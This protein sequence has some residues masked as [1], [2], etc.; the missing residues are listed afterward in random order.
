MSPKCRYPSCEEE[1][2]GRGE[3]VGS[4]AADFCSPACE[5]KFE[6]VRADARDARRAAKAERRTP[7]MR[8]G[9]P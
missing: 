9:R 2:R 8:G 1:A 3:N 4:F 6:H 5:L 7:A